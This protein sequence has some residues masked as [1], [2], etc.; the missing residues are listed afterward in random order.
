MSPPR[1]RT[2]AKESEGRSLKETDSK[3]A[4]LHANGKRRSTMNSRAAYDE[5][6]MLRRALEE[7]KGGATESST[8]GPRKTKRARDESDE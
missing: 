6:E 1:K 3:N 2:A 8:S 5:D 4:G 7:S